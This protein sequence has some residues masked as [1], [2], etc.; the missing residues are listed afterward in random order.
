MGMMKMMKRFKRVVVIVPGRSVSLN[1]LAALSNGNIPPTLLMQEK[2]DEIFEAVDKIKNG[3]GGFGIVAGTGTGKTVSLRDIIGRVLSEEIRIDVV[4]REHEATDYTWTCNVLVVTPGVALHWLKS[5]IITNEDLIVIDEIHQTS[6]HLELSM[7]IAKKLGCCFVWMSATIDPS[8]YS[9]YLEASTVIE[10]SAF[11]PTK[12]SE[13]KCLRK[14]PEEFLSSQVSNFIEEE[15]GV[16][17]FVPTREMAERLSREYYSNRGLYCDFY[18][19]GEKAEKLRQFLKGEVP[20]PFMIFMTIAGA[21]S[22]NILGL[23]TV[24]IVDEMYKEIVHSGVRV[25]EKVELGN[26]ELIQMAGRVLGR[27][28]NSLVC[29]LTGRCSSVD[30]CSLKPTAPEFAIGGDLREVALTCARLGVNANELDLIAPINSA[31]Y[32]AEVNRFKERGIIESEGLTAYGKK[33]ERLPV[34]PSWA[35]LIVQSQNDDRRLLDIVAVSA[36]VESLYSLLRKNADLSGVKVNGSDHLTAYNIVVSALNRFGYLRKSSDREVE[37]AFQGDWFRKRYNKQTGQTEKNMGG[38]VQWCDEHGFNARAIKEV[39]IAMKSV[40]RQLRLR[41]RMPDPQNLQIIS[42]NDDLHKEF[43]DLLARVQSLDFVRDERNSQVGTVWRAKHSLTDGARVLGKIRYWSDRRGIQRATIEGTEVPEDLFKLYTDKKPDSIHQVNSEGVEIEFKLEFAGEPVGSLIEAAADSEVPAEL[44]K[45]AEQKFIDALLNRQISTGF[46]DQNRETRKLSRQLR[47][48]SGGAVEEISESKEQ[49]LYKLEFKDKEIISVRSLQ[50]AIESGK[51]NPDNLLL[52][53]EDFIPVET[54]KKIMADNPDT[55]QVEGETLA[56]EYGVSGHEFYCLAE[57]AEGFARSVAVKVE[58][59]TLP[60]GRTVELRCEGHSTKSLPELVEKLEQERIEQAWSRKRSE[61]E[62]S[63]WIS[64]PEEVFP[65][66]SKL[67][68]AVEITREDNGQGKQIIGFFS[69]KSD[70]YPDFKIKIRKSE[71]E[72]REE[73]RIGLERLFQKATR[74]EREIP[75]EEPWS[76]DLGETLK[77]RLDS[78]IK[79]HAEN[80]TPKN[81]MGQIEA[82]KAEVKA[83]KA[84]IAERHAEAQQLIAE[85][86]AELNAKVEAIMADDDEFVELEISQAREEVRKAKDYLKSAA[87][88]DVKGACEAA[89]R[90]LPEIIEERKKARELLSKAEKKMDSFREKFDKKYFYHI[91]RREIKSVMEMFNRATI[92]A[93]EKRYDEVSSLSQDILSE[94]KRLSEISLREQAS[95]KVIQGHI[96]HYYNKC[97]VCASAI[98]WD[99]Y[100]YYCGNDH[101]SFFE[102]EEWFRDDGDYDDDEKEI[103]IC[104]SKTEDET[105]IQVT[106][107]SNYGYPINIKVNHILIDSDEEIVFE[108]V[109]R[110]MTEQQRKVTKLKRELA[111]LEEKKKEAEETEKKILSSNDL[112]SASEL[113]QSL[114]KTFVQAQ[115]EEL[116]KRAKSYEEKDRQRKKKKK[117]AEESFGGLIELSFEFDKDKGFFADI[118]FNDFNDKTASARFIIEYSEIGNIYEG[119]TYLCR[120]SSIVAIHRKGIILSV[121]ILCERSAADISLRIE[122]IKKEKEAAE[123][124]AGAGEGAGEG[125]EEGEEIQTVKSLI[126]FLNEKWK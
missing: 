93:A 114:H 82:V 51:V 57:V 103:V 80:L 91:K 5:R 54:Q 95:E 3:A 64:N 34:E 35:E 46:A 30:L 98:D 68:S 70:F 65:H 72:A 104:Q 53:L 89:F 48:R 8:I 43:V 112:L 10:C 24:V 102:G 15:R 1:T 99:D 76:G 115:K 44:V 26:N 20:K 18:H 120:V 55:V 62:S 69:L 2:R 6:K 101:S 9:E 16:A 83:A 21:S 17:V 28:E 105:L 41:V 7:A 47:I 63:S 125:E 111:D 59:V 67:L 4:T 92:A 14:T 31:L 73:T 121:C 84:E 32:E 87:Y 39:A 56:V 100:D 123:K 22:L 106:V 49:E 75:S 37:Y 52:K 79:E 23:D 88:G 61:L 12:R 122:E 74:E 25:L 81:F 107:A 78:L 90:D 42:E 71:E 109:W 96:E 38:F 118:P 126:S 60:G 108:Q 66:L 40:Y 116:Y 113:K 45:Q 29:I 77:N 27:A 13:V 50:S 110:P 117:I 86:E 94:V 58:V 36:C 124:E 19:G 33:V 85:T 11:D 119:C 97:P